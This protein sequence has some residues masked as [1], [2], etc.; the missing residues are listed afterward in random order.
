MKYTLLLFI[1]LIFSS[2]HCTKQAV[3]SLN[4]HPD[5]IIGLQPLDNFTKAETD[6]IIKA[7]SNFFSKRVTLLKTIN[8]P[9]NFFNAS[10]NQYAA[11]SILLLLSK[12]INDSLVEVV[13]IT[14]QPIFTIKKM[15]TQPYYDQNLFGFGYQPGNVCVVSDLKFSTA[16]TFFF[17][18]R[19]RNVI[20]HEIGHNL[21]LPHCADD[22]CIM[23]KNNGDIMTLDNCGNDYCN[24]CRK[25]LRWPAHFQ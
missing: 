10:V 23:S 24:A 3:L 7:L 16:N 19:M 14:H 22:K 1:A 11:D 6:S 4:N 20:L 17:N 8:I 5:Q 13:G 12:Q 15:G 9:A 2:I 18:R 21:G 25:K